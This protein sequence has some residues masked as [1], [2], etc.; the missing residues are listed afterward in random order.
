VRL[1]AV[2]ARLGGQLGL[3]LWEVDE[4]VARAFFDASV[5]AAEEADDPALSAW[6]AEASSKCREDY[7]ALVDDVRCL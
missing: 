6:V 1:A 7:A 5:V 4:P 3:L 2:A